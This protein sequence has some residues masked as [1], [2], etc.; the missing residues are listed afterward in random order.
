MQTES[1]NTVS[2]C[3]DSQTPDHNAEE[4]AICNLIFTH[5]IC[6]PTTHVFYYDPSK[7]S[8]IGLRMIDSV[9]VQIGGVE[10][11]HYVYKPLSK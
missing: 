3:T 2:G 5:A 11:D 8:N 10:T 6:G 4:C 9:T 1:N 7:V